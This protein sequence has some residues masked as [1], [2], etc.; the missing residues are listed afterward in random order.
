MP[1]SLRPAPPV[2]PGQL[3]QECLELPRQFK[4]RMKLLDVDGAAVIFTMVA[5]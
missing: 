4:V 1:L 3:L 2:D 5:I